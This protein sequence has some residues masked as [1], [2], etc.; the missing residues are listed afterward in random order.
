M[1]RI[2]LSAAV[3]RILLLVALSYTIQTI[4]GRAQPL[5]DPVTM[6]SAYARTATA[7]GFSRWSTVG[8]P[9]RRASPA[10]PSPNSDR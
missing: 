8:P 9:G 5:P 6:L 3:N 10:T 2:P 1:N 7:A 4:S